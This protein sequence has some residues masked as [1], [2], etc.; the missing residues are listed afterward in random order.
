MN[1]GQVNAGHIDQFHTNGCVFNDVSRDGKNNVSMGKPSKADKHKSSRVISHCFL[2]T[3]ESRP[4]GIVDSH[5]I[6]LLFEPT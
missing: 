1:S 2:L 3:P 6:A 4:R 5:F